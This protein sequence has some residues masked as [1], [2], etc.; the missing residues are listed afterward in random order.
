MLVHTW[1]M[2]TKITNTLMSWVVDADPAA[3]AQAHRAARL[4]IIAGHVALDARR[5][6]RD[7]S[8]RR[9]G[10]SDRGRDHSAAV[11]VDLGCGM[12]AIRTD[13]DASIFPTASTGCSARSR[14]PCRPAS[15]WPHALRPAPPICGSKKHPYPGR[16]D[17]GVAKKVSQPVRLARFS[18]NH[19]VEV[20]LDEADRV[21]L[22]LHSGSRG[23]GNQLAQ[24]HIAGQ[25]EPLPALDH[26]VDDPDLA[27]FVQGT[28]GVR[29]RTSPTCRGLR[30]TR[31]RT[32]K[33]CSRR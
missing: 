4:P 14:L 33:Q 30:P 18:G 28:D 2:P 3:I 27:W 17:N 26:V 29:R 19:F 1:R 25:G 21:W 20:C 11:G 12:A 32:V 13:L 24:R 22:F 15:A 8:N 31:S 6:R 16:L 10:H 23:I 5:P 7:R 9:V